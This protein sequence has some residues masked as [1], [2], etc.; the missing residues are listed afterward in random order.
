MADRSLID[1]AIEETLRFR[2]PLRGNMRV[3][4]RDTELGG[5]PIP[6]CEALLDAVLG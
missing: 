1:N 4:T 2:G 3:V 5:V 6:K